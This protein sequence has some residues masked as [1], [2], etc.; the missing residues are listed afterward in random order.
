MQFNPFR[1]P[2]LL[3]VLAVIAS[4]KPSAE[5]R[6]AALHSTADA[7]LAAYND[8]YQRLYTAAAEAEWLLNTHIVEGDTATQRAYERARKAYTDF[9]GSQANIDSARKYLDQRDQLTP[10]QEK[11]FDAI[12]FAAGASPATAADAVKELITVQGDQTKI[13]YGFDFRIDNRSVT[14]N[15]I[16]NILA[17]DAGLTQKRKAWEASKEVG[18]SLKPGLVKLRDL[19]N[20]SVRGLG[21]SDFFTYQVSEYGMTSEEMLDMTGGFIRDVWPLYRELHTWARYE[22]AKRY[23]QPVPEYL[24]ADWLPNQW[25]QDWAAMVK[26]EGLNIDGALQTKSA[27]WIVRTGEEFYKSLGFPALPPSFYEKS[28]LYPLPPDA[29]YKKNNH[30]SAW[31]M[32]LKDD[33]RSLMSVEANAEWW[34]T[35]LHELGHVYYFMAY[36]R[37]EVPYVL[38][39]GANRAFHEAIGSQIGLASLQKPLLQSQ[40]LVPADATTDDTMKLLADALN[41]VVLIPWAAGVMTRFEHQLYA[42][43]LS[44]DKFNETWWALAKQ[45]QG[46]VPPA[47]RGEEYCDACTKTHIIDDPAQYYDYAMAEILL[48]QFHDHIAKNILNQSVHATNYWGSQETGAFL[49]QLMETGATVD[50]REHLQENLGTAVSA[51]PLLDYFSPLMDWLK[52]QNE[53]RTHTLPETP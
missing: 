28:S 15:D 51:R 35:T 50:W 34:E 10:L 48:F 21:F 45:Y 53:G 24:P 13:L 42:E 33:V 52:A 14:K 19:R 20:E 47:D 12:L 44:P 26:V 29:D 25:A 43:E 5:E 2:L 16:N 3:A 4:C 11:Q 23:N 46:I 30:A 31:H 6:K 27:E 37:P 36:T 39:E 8:E 7:Y 41:H 22:L 49:K 9:R 17:S 38:R 32:D 1:H 40:G 18:R